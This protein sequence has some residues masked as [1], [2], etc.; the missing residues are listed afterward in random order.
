VAQ[1]IYS[2]HIGGIP[3]MNAGTGVVATAHLTGTAVSS[4]SVGSGGSGFNNAPTVALTGGGGTG[5][6]ATAS[7]SS[8]AVTGFTV[9]NGGTGYTSAPTVVINPNTIMTPITQVDSTIFDLYFDIPI[10]Q[11]LYFEA[12]VDAILTANPIP[13][14]SV[15]AAALAGALSYQIGQKADAS[16]IV[17]TLKSLF[18]AAY[19]TGAAVSLDNSTWVSLVAPTSINYQFMIPVG[20]ITLS[21]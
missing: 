14:L 10:P 20:N 8:G 15:I 21:S 2:K 16:A 6:T 1:A 12:Q 9:T 3:Q 18:P 17:E 5:A 11:N 19:I 13:A 7:I 4:I